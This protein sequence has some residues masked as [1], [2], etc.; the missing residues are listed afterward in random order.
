MKPQATI[1]PGW[2]KNGGD[3]GLAVSVSVMLEGWDEDGAPG[4]GP[5]GNPLRAGVYDT[6]GRSWSDYGPKAGAWRLLDILS[7][8]KVRAVFYVSGIVAERYPELMMA[9]VAAGHAVAAHSWSQHM[10]PAYLSPEAETADIGRC[11]A[12]IERTTGRRPSGWLSPR[13]TPSAS[14]STLIAAAGYR[15][16]ADT[17]DSDLPYAVQTVSGALLAVPFTMEIND[18]PLYI[19]YGNEPQAFTRTLERLLDQWRVLPKGTACMDITAHAHVFGRPAG[20]VEFAKSL[21]AV[22]RREQCA[23]LTSHH[24]IEQLWTLEGQGTVNRR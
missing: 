14:T 18:M 15:W 2:F 4:I 5:M 22:K 6:Q 13:C 3:Q 20:A 1:P 23:W 19:R 16:H 10:I 7:A 12:V 11:T 8:E 17:F 21:Q 9:I 24:E